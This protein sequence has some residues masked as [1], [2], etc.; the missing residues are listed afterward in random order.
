[1]SSDQDRRDPVVRLFGALLMGVGVLMMTLCGLC[2]LTVIFS[3]AGGGVS[4]LLGMLPVALVVGG[5]PIA[6]GFGIFW[7]GRWLRGPKG[8]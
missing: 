5:A 1:M 7:L 6:V 4:D 3:V 2:S 8:P